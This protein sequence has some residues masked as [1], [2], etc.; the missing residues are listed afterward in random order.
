M[1]IR[2][3]AHCHW[4]N[5]SY[6]GRSLTW[7]RTVV[8][9]TIDAEVVVCYVGVSVSRWE[10]SDRSSA[11]RVSDEV[12]RGGATASRGGAIN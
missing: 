10:L 1:G 2:P 7:G 9:A 6:T 11:I 8:T 4:W 12:F 3:Y 5:E